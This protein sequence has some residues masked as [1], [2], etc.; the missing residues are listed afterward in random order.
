VFGTAW[1][2]SV[3]LLLAAGAFWR[4]P[5]LFLIGLTLA[6]A[7]GV[8]NA[9]Q[10][11]CLDRV[12]YRRQL[13][14][15]RALFGDEVDLTVEVVN[16]KLLPL[17]W[18]E[19]EDEL[20]RDLTMVRGQA[21]RSYKP[22]RAVLAGVLSLRWYERVRRHYRLH[23]RAR[24]EHHFGPVRLRSG[25]VFGFDSRQE[26]RELYDSLLVYPKVV[27]IEALG[28]PA[29]DPFGDRRHRDFLF[30]D[31]L[32]VVGLREY[33]LGD[34]PRRI[35][36][37]ATARTGDLQVR[38]LEATTSHRLMLLLDLNTSPSERRFAGY[39]PERLELAIVVAA[40]VAS[41]A[42]DNGYQIGLSANG[43]QQRSAHAVR[44]PT[45]GDPDQLSTVL[46]ALARALPFPSLGFDELIHREAHE[47][48]DGAT[49]VVVA[50]TIGEPV[51]AELAALRRAGHPITVLLLSPDA[52]S[53]PGIVTHPIPATP[54]RDLEAL[55]LS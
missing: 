33:V 1:I 16:R 27:P 23:C 34:S 52:S 4:D 18:L 20:P 43:H 47:L 30:E 54:W 2:V 31:P 13:G 42:A 5:L 8:A 51:A 12:E 35:D 19:I 11:R 7:A 10:R 45:A 28:L 49:L 17:A 25:D 22:G 37:K 41:W 38:L 21:A 3:G 6:L 46:E 40:S 32:N 29:R 53:L 39:D 50:A 55:S 24:G 36:W 14:Q 15:R 48:P 26:E 44:V 9:W